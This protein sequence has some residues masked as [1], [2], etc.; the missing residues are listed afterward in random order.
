MDI[1]EGGQD[2]YYGWNGDIDTE[3]INYL[4]DVLGEKAYNNIEKYATITMDFTMF[5]DFVLEVDSWVNCF[6]ML[7]G[8]TEM[9]GEM[10]ALESLEN[11]ELAEIES[12][13][14]A[15]VETVTIETVEGEVVE[16]EAAA[17]SGSSIGNVVNCNENSNKY[18]S[19]FW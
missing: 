14:L 9:A 8:E 17:E 1:I 5:A 18:I 3:T 10:A 19:N 12:V 15:N 7:S 4:K 2:I 11:V 13:E 16:V 6:G